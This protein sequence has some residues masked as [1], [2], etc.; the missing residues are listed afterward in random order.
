M[1]H[2]TTKKVH[3]SQLMV[4]DTVMID[5]KMQTVGKNHIS[6]SDL[7]GYQ[8]KGYCHHES[9]GMMDVVIFPRWIKGEI[10]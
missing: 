7:F 9:K 10:N 2:Y 6:K 4:G 3:I 1:G 8:Y 5:G